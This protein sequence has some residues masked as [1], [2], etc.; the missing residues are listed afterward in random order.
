LEKRNHTELICLSGNHDDHPE[1]FLSLAFGRFNV[2]KGTHPRH[3]RRK[4]YLL[5]HGEDFDSASTS[6]NQ[7]S[8]IKGASG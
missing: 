7:K 8:A 5:V 2:A 1:R 3:L 4:R 6:K